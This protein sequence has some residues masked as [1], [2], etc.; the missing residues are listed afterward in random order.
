MREIDRDGNR[1]RLKD[2]ETESPPIHWLISITP[3]IDGAEL[4]W[5]R[6]ARSHEFNP[7]LSL[8]FQELNYLSHLHCPQ[9][10]HWQEARVRG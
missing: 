2:R 9:N 7:G 1:D 5:G 4:G 8:G 10:L 6:G 3:T